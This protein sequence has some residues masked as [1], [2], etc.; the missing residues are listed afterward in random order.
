MGLALAVG[1]AAGGTA[2]GNDACF[3]NIRSSRAAGG[4]VSW[5]EQARR[6]VHE[7][8]DGLHQGR[9]VQKWAARPAV[10]GGAVARDAPVGGT[11]GDRLAPAPTPDPPAGV[12]ASDPGLREVRLTWAAPEALAASYRIERGMKSD[13]PF[14]RIADA[15]PGRRE[16][17]DRGG[18]DAPLTDGTP[19]YYRIFAVSAAGRESLPSPV[20]EGLTAPPPDPPARLAAQ[21]HAS[22]AVRLTWEPPRSEGVERYVVER[23]GPGA[24]GEFARVAEATGAVYEEGGTPGSELRDSAEY[25]YRVTA[26]NRVGAVGA[27]SDPVDVITRPPPAAPRNLLAASDEVRCVPLTWDASP[28]DDVTGYAL[29]RSEGEGG[30]FTHLAWIPGRTTTRY[31]D[32]TRDPG[33]LADSRTY[34]YRIAATNAVGSFGE[35]S[36]PVRATTRDPPLAVE[37]LA[38]QSN[39][40]RASRLT[41]TP[42][43]DDRVTGYAIE[44]APDDGE[45]K[46]IGIVNGRETSAYDDRGGSRRRDGPGDL[47]D[48]A[49]CRYRVCAFNTA[50][51]RSPWS[52]EAR[53]RTKPAPAAPTGLLATDAR[54]RS[55]GL[56]WDANAEA[57]IAAYVVEWRAPDSARWRAVARVES[58]AG[59]PPAATD[60]RLDDGEERIY[61]VQAVDAD[62]LASAWSEEARGR[63]KSLP[64]APS[65]VKVEWAG[66]EALVSWTAPRQK[67]VTGYA[68]W[69]QGLL[70]STK[71]AETA[72]TSCRL[73]PEKVGRGISVCVTS[74]DRDGLASEASETL[75]LRRPPPRA[76]GGGGGE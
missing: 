33:T 39:Q 45:F 20:T 30:E 62:T 59:P 57:D 44:R 9:G 23:A 8:V 37:D 58:R 41:W 34:V 74:V 48:G 64:D 49:A 10:G 65:D 14:I 75:Q 67:D 35:W 69:Q 46:E 11:G 54:P 12:A 7:I 32:G 61:R 4:A 36:A 38:A 52:R 66:H 42:S 19:Y 50:G 16:Y 60:E 73:P 55:V 56:T 70:R 76:D 31:L 53:A 28:E 68:V 40:P 3:R 2:D 13:G 21:A 72:D 1:L 6:A 24:S 17:R 27:P 25:R 63:A 5:P 43:T 29:S 51:A 47:P 22:R 26:V 15:P 71:I 18:P